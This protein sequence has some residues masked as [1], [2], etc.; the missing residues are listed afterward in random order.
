MFIV[1][2]L[3]NTEELKKK[4]KRKK[5]YNHIQREKIFNIF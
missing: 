4:E 1:E 2:N 5:I 3:D